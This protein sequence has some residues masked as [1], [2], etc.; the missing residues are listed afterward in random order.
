MSPNNEVYKE[1]DRDECLAVA[2][3]WENLIAERR[4]ADFRVEVSHYH[5]TDLIEIFSF[6]SN[7]F[8]SRAFRLLTKE[9][10]AELFLSFDNERMERIIAIVSDAELARMLDEMYLDDTVDII[11][12]MPAYIVKRILRNSTEEDREALG[13]LLL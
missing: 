1:P 8:E 12:E 4:Y 10:A 13:K 7:E 6:I 2:K 5:I 3:E 9:Q 11:E